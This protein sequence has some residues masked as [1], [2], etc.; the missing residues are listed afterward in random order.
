MES[1]GGRLLA[2]VLG[3][4]THE[5]ARTCGC[6]CTVQRKGDGGRG[7]GES[8]RKG[9]GET[10]LYMKKIK[11]NKRIPLGFFP[12]SNP[13]RQL[14]EEGWLQFSVSLC[15]E[16]QVVVGGYLRSVDW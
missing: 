2:S 5:L 13:V 16:W 10:F 12:R 3:V 14:L 6:A 7:E 15:A 4:H 1:K 8:R 11:K 9:L